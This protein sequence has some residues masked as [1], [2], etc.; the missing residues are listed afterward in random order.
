MFHVLQTCL[1]SLIFLNHLNSPG[2]SRRVSSMELI[3][4][5]WRCLGGIS[6]QLAVECYRR[7]QPDVTLWSLACRSFRQAK[8]FVNRAANHRER[9]RW[10]GFPHLMSETRL[11]IIM[12][13]GW[14]M[15]MFPA[16]ETHWQQQQQQFCIRWRDIKMWILYFGCFVITDKLDKKS[17]LMSFLFAPETRS[18]SLWTWITQHNDNRISFHARIHVEL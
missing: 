6:G 7:G 1:D 3:L 14:W 18:R 9:Y 16:V 10:T 11:I 17:R 8:S 4:M 13:C 12:M 15:Q 2:N 5:Y